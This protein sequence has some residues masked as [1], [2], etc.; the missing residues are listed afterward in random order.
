MMGTAASGACREDDVE[1][2]ILTVPEVARLLRIPKSTIY[3]LVRRGELPGQKVGK[4]W[5][6][7]REHIR[8]LMG[9]THV[10]P[11]GC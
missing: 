3:T 9:A 1:L 2:E 8:S 5:R 4:H 10:R 7:T 11:K 6:I